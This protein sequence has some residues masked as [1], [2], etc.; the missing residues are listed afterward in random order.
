[1]LTGR[2][3]KENSPA[4]TR[5]LYNICATS[6]QRLWRWSNTV[7]ISYKKI[8]FTGNTEHFT[9]E[10]L[11]VYTLNSQKVYLR[12][13]VKLKKSK[14]LRKTW[15]WVGGSSPKSDFLE[16]EFCVFCTFCVI[17]FFSDFFYLF[18]LTDP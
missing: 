4:N 11:C 12:G 7:Q 1:M 3:V 9:F 10:I 8:V 17:V 14:N 16:G 15:K 2:E 18:K 13:F 6:A 5:H